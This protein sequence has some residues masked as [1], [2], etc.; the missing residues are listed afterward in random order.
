M[1]EKLKNQ[2][3]RPAFEIIFVYCEAEGSLDVYAPKNGR[4]IADLQT[5]FARHILK[6]DSLAEWKKIN[7]VMI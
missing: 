7:V 4:A 1:R 6:L 2:A 3:H 5:L